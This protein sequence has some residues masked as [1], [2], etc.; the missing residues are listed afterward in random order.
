VS[1]DADT[2]TTALEAD[3]TFQENYYG[4]ETRNTS[5]TFGE[6]ADGDDHSVLV[7]QRWQTED[8]PDVVGLT[9]TRIETVRKMLHG[10]AES[11]EFEDK[12]GAEP[13]AGTT[14]V[15]VGEAAVVSQKLIG[16]RVADVVTLT[17]KHLTRIQSAL[18]DDGGE[19]DGE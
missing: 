18:E 9:G 16:E 3:I 17:T 5:I 2:S 13:V 10:N 19:A 15:E 4:G 6:T 11:R 8:R 7:E 14:K 12:F 1:T